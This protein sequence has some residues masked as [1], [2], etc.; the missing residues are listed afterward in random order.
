MT[1]EE[2]C[3]V[4]AGCNLATLSAAAKAALTQERAASAE[5][6][7]LI[8]Q[9]AERLHRMKR[10]SLKIEPELAKLGDLEPAVRRHLKKLIGAGPNGAS[11]GS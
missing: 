4:R 2:R 9:Q 8:Y 1:E 6:Q 10:N 3:A 7:R 5:R 11:Q